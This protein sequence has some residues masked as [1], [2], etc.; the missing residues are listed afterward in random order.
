MIVRPATL[1]GSAVVVAGLEDY[2]IVALDEIYESMFLINP[3]RPGASESVT[4]L[5]GLADAVERVASD[6]IQQSV[7]AL[8]R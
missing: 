2:H 3:T 4:K 1:E 6:V 8:E 5:F 7:D